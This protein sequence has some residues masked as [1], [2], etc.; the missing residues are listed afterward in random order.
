MF[1]RDEVKN[2]FEKCQLISAYLN[3]TN[4][5][6]LPKKNCVV[7]LL[8]LFVDVFRYWS[9]MGNLVKSLVNSISSI[10]ALL[11]L[12]CLFIF[13][14]ALLGMQIFGGRSVRRLINISHFLLDFC[15]IFHFFVREDIIK[16]WAQH[17]FICVMVFLSCLKD[18]L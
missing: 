9:A 5:L 17:I 8:F 7:K 2:A 3:M 15:E 16:E 10:V 6:R 18:I 4:S 1:E 13:I 12:L 11:V 14:F